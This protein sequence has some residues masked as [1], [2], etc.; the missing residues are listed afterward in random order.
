MSNSLLRGDL[1]VSSLLVA[2]VEEEIL[3]DLE[4]TPDRFWGGLS[5]IVTTLG[6]TNRALLERRDELQRAID[7]WFTENR[8]GGFDPDSQR[9]FLQEIGYLVD[10]PATVQISPANVDTEWLY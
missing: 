8:V 3:C 5:T 9:A 6:P 2:L 10:E 1:T 4:I 7:A